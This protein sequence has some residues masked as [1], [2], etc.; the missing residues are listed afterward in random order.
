[1]GLGKVMGD[2]WMDEHHHESIRR[3]RRLQ[4]A[5]P[6]SPS[7]PRWPPQPQPHNSIN[8]AQTLVGTGP[9]AAADPMPSIAPRPIKTKCSAAAAAAA[10]LLPGSS[11]TAAAANPQHAAPMSPP[12]AAAA[13]RGALAS[14]CASVSV[15][16]CS[17]ASKT[18]ASNRPGIRRR[19]SSS[20]SLLLPLAL[21]LLAA[22][23]RDRCG[24]PHALNL[25]VWMH[26][27]PANRFLFT[28]L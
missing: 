23:A 8:A 16:W 5:A 13:A 26:G 1:M 7:P 2:R 22:R 11:H 27:L 17:A 12:A 14:W 19:P 25:P 4:Q 6:N 28:F 3:W 10:L 21:A 9:R 24:G 18:G 20:C 15:P